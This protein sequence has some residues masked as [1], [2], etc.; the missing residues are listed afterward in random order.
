M[1][2]TLAPQALPTNLLYLPVPE[3]TCE[4]ELNEPSRGFS[5]HPTSA[6]PW[7]HRHYLKD[8]ALPSCAYF[9]LLRSRIQTRALT[10]VFILPGQDPKIL[11]YVF[12][13]NSSNLT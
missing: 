8:S 2:L 6:H 7:F 10:W 13:L 3:L 12:H 9:Q 1:S 5:G 4:T 11:I